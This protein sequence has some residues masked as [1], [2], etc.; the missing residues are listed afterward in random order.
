MIRKNIGAID[1]DKA[2]QQGLV[3]LTEFIVPGKK[4]YTR[5]NDG[6]EV[7]RG[8]EWCIRD[9]RRRNGIK[10]ESGRPRPYLIGID[11][12]IYGESF[13]VRDKQGRLAVFGIVEKSTSDRR[14][15]NG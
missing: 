1:I 6:M 8:E 11:K 14:R 5:G 13:I 12:N 2:R 10:D 4:L 9:V 3:Q 7:I 15:K